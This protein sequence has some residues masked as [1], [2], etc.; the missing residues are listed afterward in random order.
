MLHIVRIA[1]YWIMEINLNIHGLQLLF[2][3]FDGLLA[4][5]LSNYD[6]AHIK[7]LRAIHLH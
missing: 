5:V 7:A 3:A 1:F 2:K 4:L 6:A